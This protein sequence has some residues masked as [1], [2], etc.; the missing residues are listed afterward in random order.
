MSGRLTIGIALVA[1][2]LLFLLG[3]VDVVD[4]PGAVLGSWWPL[5]FVLL[6]GALTSIFGDLDVNLADAKPGDD[7]TVDISVLFGDVTVRQ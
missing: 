6:G 1:V 7:M 5:V 2:G 4:E 3:A